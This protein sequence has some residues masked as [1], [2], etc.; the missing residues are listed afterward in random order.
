M[1]GGLFVRKSF[2]FF[3]AIVIMAILMTVLVSADF[4]KTN[5]YVDGTF[6]DVNIEDWYNDSVKDAYEYG[7]MNGVSATEFSPSGNLT[8]AEGIAI[9]AR[10]HAAIENKS[11]K[12]STGEWYQMYVDYAIQNGIVA[13]DTFFDYNAIIKRSEIATMLAKVCEN[14]PAINNFTHVADVNEKAPFINDVL[15]LYNAGILTGSDSYGNFL[16]DSNLTRAEIATMAVRIADSNKRVKKQ[17]DE[18]P[19]RTYSDGYALI[20]NISGTGRTNRS[21]ANGWKYDNRFEFDNTSGWG[22]KYVSDVDDTA[23]T[24]LI[25]EFE[26]ESE[27]VLTLEMLI[28]LWSKDGGLYIAF[29]NEDE[30]RLFGLK[31]VDGKWVIYGDSEEVTDVAVPEVLTL[32]SFVCYVDLDKNT[33]SVYI[34]NEKIGMIDIPADAEL[35]KLVLGTNAVGSGSVNIS[36]VKLFKNY[37]V[38]DRFAVL[39]EN[40]G[41]IPVN[42]SV[43]GDFT[44]QKKDVGEGMDRFS[45]RSKTEAGKT[46]YAI[47]N[48]DAVCGNVDV[49]THILLPDASDGASFSLLAAGGEVLSLYTKDGKFFVGDK[50]LRSF[51]KNIWQDIHVEANTENGEA[52]IRINSK[53]VATVPFNAAYIDG[54]K[55]TFSPKTNSEMW[56]DDLEIQCLVEHDDYVPEP[57]VAQTKYNIGMYSC[58]LWRDTVSGEGWDAVSGLPEFEPWLGYYDEGLRETADWEIKQMVEHGFNFLNVCWFSPADNVKEPIKRSRISHSA[59]HDGFLNA[60]YSDLMKFSILW[61]TSYGGAKT[62][63]QFEEYIWNYW[64]DY[65]LSDERYLSFDNKAVISIYVGPSKLIEMFGSEDAVYEVMEFCEDDIKSLGYDGIIWLTIRHYNTE[66]RAAEIAGMFDGAMALN[67]GIDGNNAF[68]QIEQYKMNDKYA[69]KYDLIHIPTSQISYNGVARYN[70]RSAYI[71]VED[72]LEVLKYFKEEIDKRNTGT[73][74]DN[75]LQLGCMNEFSEGHSIMPMGEFGY[76]YLDN[77]RKVFTDEPEEHSELDIK[78][79]DEQKA[80]ITHLYPDNYSPITWQM[81]EASDFERM[82]NGTIGSG[83]YKPAVTWDMSTKEGIAAWSAGHGLTNYNA[84]N[85]KISATALGDCAINANNLSIDISKTPVLHIRMDSSINYWM[86]IYFT[87]EDSITMGAD[88]CVSFKGVEAGEHDYYIDMSINENWKGT[89]T[90]LRIDP[91]NAPGDFSVSLVELL[92]P[93]EAGEAAPE[94]V[95]NNHDYKF[96]FTP[97]KTSDGDYE[98]AAEATIR[99]FFST[100]RLYHEFDR[101]TGEG[102]LTV[103]TRDNKTLVFNVGSDKVF[104]DG[105]E[106][107]LG[108]T[109]RMRD[110]LPMLHIKKF[111]DLVGYKYEEQDDVFQIWAATDEEVAMLIEK[112]EKLD[113]DYTKMTEVGDW[114]T[115][116]ASVAVVDGYLNIVPTGT[117]SSI[118]TQTNFNS[119]DYTHI[120]IGLK[121]TEKAEKWRINVFWTRKDEKASSERMVAPW[122]KDGQRIG[123]IIEVKCDLT[124]NENWTGDIRSI[125]FDPH[126]TLDPVYVQYIRFVKDEENASFNN[127]PKEENTEVE[128]EEED[129]GPVIVEISEDETVHEEYG[130][131]LGEISFDYS[132]NMASEVIDAPGAATHKI[133]EGNYVNEKYMDDVRL[134]IYGSKDAVIT[135]G[136]RSETKADSYIL[137][138]TATPATVYRLSMVKS[139]LKV[140]KGTYTFTIDVFFPRTSSRSNFARMDFISG[141]TGTQNNADE[142]HEN[143]NKWYTTSWTVE[144]TGVSNG[145]ATIVDGDTTRK[146]PVAEFASNA[147]F[148][149]A[150]MTRDHHYYFDNFRIYYDPGTLNN[151][152]NTADT[153]REDSSVKEQ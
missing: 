100:M 8:V 78:P 79:T 25:R 28:E 67:L 85:G 57:V 81:Y 29:E 140:M 14:L 110:G 145:K 60:K 88:K 38:F 114:T 104:V 50:E 3:F 70:T 75:T 124:E 111:C 36:H 73:W 105:V 129:T 35:K 54:V 86:Q 118:T 132:Y 147:W 24:A 63:E 5:T 91:I 23:F 82:K 144:V 13:A 48:F 52:I 128:I 153:N 121:Y 19:V 26:K 77:I 69:D 103:K 4:S 84:G 18:I 142:C 49:K 92:T 20:E 123:D 31:E 41:Q 120:V 87:T 90:K 40:A 98:V 107:E 30:D 139:N 61:E 59:I 21:I 102:V 56:F 12:T 115:R 97:A 99:G 33:M 32:V 15:K 116:Q 101:F 37:P 7:I 27:G 141:I 1:N 76:A 143:K 135:N 146:I 46:S 134:E 64:K 106:Q 151:N 43:S 2:K 108:Y 51:S 133:V 6:N 119:E 109:L 130:I 11:I 125:R 71:S 148:N 45:V 113:W 55:Y 47:R 72:H 17:F 89:L 152:S 150:D 95:I 149:N 16:P 58:Y 117:D 94:F 136:P 126:Y 44:L 65:Y 80:R 34:N 137:D 53:I 62:L 122:V 42:Y 10:I 66:E 22:K 83:N 138:I 96:V 131:L 9:A 127:K 112:S 39:D 68:N 74:V 93:K